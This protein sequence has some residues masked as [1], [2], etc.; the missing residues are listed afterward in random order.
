MANLLNS[1]I[2]VDDLELVLSSLPNLEE[3][4]GKSILITG[5]SG[6]ICSAFTDLLIYAKQ[7]H[8]LSL[9][10]YALGRDVDKLKARFGDQVESCF[11]DSLLPLE[12]EKVVDYVV[13]GAG[14]A[15]PELYVNNP[16]E[17]MLGNIVG[18]NNLLK[19]AV[20][21]QVKKVLY[22][23]SSEVYG[24]KES[25]EAF[26]ETQYG[27]VDILSPRSSYPSSK[28]AT[29]TLLASYY[30]QHNVNFNTVRLG[31]IYGPTANAKDNKISSQFAY[32]SARGEDLIM[33][34]AGT[35]MRSYCHCLDCASAMLT[36]LLKGKPAQAY[37]VAYEKSS[38]TIR[39]MV[40]ILAK[41]GNVNI[42]FAMPSDEES[43]AFNP[44]D[45]SLLDNTKLRELGW[46][47]KIGAERGLTNT[48]K[49]IKEFLI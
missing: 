45:N 27:Y 17:T 3:L 4:N 35:Q 18:M 33:L 36:V 8:G 31:H 49:I 20:K 38:I 29:E 22:V 34:S 19:Y 39:K 12:L 16:V 6:L 25:P 13:H 26:V 5:A 44:M 42:S 32:K 11:Y 15:S 47:G 48:V 28:R 2:Y 41:A 14:N 21:N 30:K 46:Q 37:N 9:K 43:K 23:S 40:E 10:I 1:S 24:K 7:K